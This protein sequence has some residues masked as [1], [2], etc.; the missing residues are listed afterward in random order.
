MLTDPKKL[1]I[2]DTW[3]FK[4]IT[5]QSQKMIEK[6]GISNNWYNTYNHSG[7]EINLRYWRSRWKNSYENINCK[8]TGTSN[9]QEIG[10]DI[11]DND[12][13]R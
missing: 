8:L 7:L 9:S 10:A 4:E 6:L 12:K 1:K 5:N 3:Y 11:S 13:A 2:N